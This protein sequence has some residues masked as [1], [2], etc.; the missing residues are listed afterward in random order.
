MAGTVNPLEAFKP[1]RESAS[2]KSPPVEITKVFTLGT[3]HSVMSSREEP[4]SGFVLGV[5]Y[6]P[7]KANI[8]I[9]S[10]WDPTEIKAELAKMRE[11]GI[12]GA[13]VFLL[14]EDC[15]NFSGGLKQECAERFGEFLEAALANGVKVFPTLLV[16]HMSGKNWPI[17]WD[18]ESRIYDQR[19]VEGFK[20][21]AREVVWRFKGHPAIGGWILTNEVTL[22][23]RPER[24]ED[25]RVWLSELY[26]EIKGLDS[27]RPISVGDSVAP[28]SP[29][30]LKPENVKGIVDYASPHIYLYDHDPV[31]HTMSYLCTLEYCRSSGIP[32][33]LEEFG[34]PTYLYSEESQAQFID[35]VL[36]GSLVY[37]AKGAFVWCFTDFEREEDEPYLWEPHE[38]SFG[39][40]RRDGTEKR[41]TSLIRRFA[42]KLRR[43]NLSDFSVPKRDAAILVPPWF[44]RDYPFMSEP[45][46][47]WDH[48][49]VLVQSFTL[50]RSASLQVTFAREDLPLDYKLL[51]LPSTTRLFTTTSS[52]VLEFVKRGGV[53]YYSAL[54]TDFHMTATHLWDELFG[55]E[56]DLNAG[57]P[58]EV[59]PREILLTFV[60]DFAGFRVGERVELK[61]RPNTLA[62]SVSQKDAR[63]VAVDQQGKPRI[64]AVK[65]GSGLAILSTVPM[66]AFLA[67]QQVGH[68]AELVKFYSGLA[69]LAG[70]SR[71]FRVDAEGVEVQ[72]L[73]GKEGL[74]AAV[75]NHAYEERVSK[76]WYPAGLEVEDMDRV[77]VEG[78]N[79]AIL[80]LRPKSAALLYFRKS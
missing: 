65:R 38:L 41:A 12:N 47:R 26:W 75:I 59:L 78:G 57:L 50:A 60:Q 70:V 10:K 6:W 1:E 49:R 56:P 5:N 40:L 76:L 73:Q 31:R 24:A 72:Y 77:V 62:Y 3:F 33:V 4:W 66:E 68:S 22:V 32:V 34:F 51:F 46:A 64:F 63:P 2:E 61:A 54:R 19:S 15:A 27:G 79:P 36:H 80:R 71:E 35:V 67:W 17:P 55:V 53:A 39:I 44:H 8:R 45:S 43:I 29:V 18:P 69:D 11:L 16:G 20:R 48:S 52:K 37:G 21:F 30:F 9:W 23:R 74:L 14:A 42:E 13:R 7:R 28:Y 58:G 25:F